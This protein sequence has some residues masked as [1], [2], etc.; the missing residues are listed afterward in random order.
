MTSLMLPW[1]VEA[2]TL[3]VSYLCFSE[4]EAQ[5]PEPRG[6]SLRTGD[7][8]KRAICNHAAWI[9]CGHCLTCPESRCS[10]SDRRGHLSW[11][12]AQNYFYKNRLGSV[13]DKTGPPATTTVFDIPL[14]NAMRTRSAAWCWPVTAW[15]IRLLPELSWPTLLGA[16]TRPRPRSRTRRTRLPQGRPPSAPNGR[17]RARSCLLGGL[18][19]NIESTSGHRRRRLST[20][21]ICPCIG[22][23]SVE[24][25]RFTSF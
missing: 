10:R 3:F 13:T 20:S 9:L 17:A 15:E 6:L 4:L 8:A 22:A 21:P 18:F 16:S 19:L 25:G 5:G 14:Y 2:T 12:A 1:V 24:A 11:A 7:F 23:V